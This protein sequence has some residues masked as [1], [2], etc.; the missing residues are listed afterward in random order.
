MGGYTVQKSKQGYRKSIVTFARQSLHHAL[1]ITVPYLMNLGEKSALKGYGTDIT[2]H[3]LLEGLENFVLKAGPHSYCLSP[4]SHHLQLP[5]PH[6]LDICFCLLQAP[7]C[8]CRTQ[9]SMSGKTYLLLFH[10]S[11]IKVAYFRNRRK[12]HFPDF[13]NV[14]LFCSIGKKILLAIVNIIFIVSRIVMLHWRTLCSTS[15][16][17]KS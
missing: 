17:S 2:F 6:L 12:T 3:P 1:H 16:L 4:P 9:T 11:L 5:L 14:I 7:L 15:V 10:S 13:M 8:V